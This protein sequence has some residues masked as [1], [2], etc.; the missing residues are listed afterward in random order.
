MLE[1]AGDEVSEKLLK[2]VAYTLELL[3]GKDFRRQHSGVRILYQEP[4][5]NTSE[6]PVLYIVPSGFFG[7]K[8]GTADSLPVLPLQQIDGIPLLFG[9]PKVERKGKRVIVYA[10]IIASAFFLVTRYEE[11][12]RRDVRDEHG[13]F[14][15][16]ESLPYRAGFIDCPIVEDYA[17]LLRK[18][19][20]EAGV[21]VEE[22]KREFTVLLTHDV[23]SIRK[24]RRI[25]QPFRQAAKAFLGREPFGSI[26]ESA[27][28]VLGLKKDPYNNFEELFELAESLDEQEVG[29]KRESVY[30][31]MSG[32][33]GKYASLYNIRAKD[34]KRIIQE[35][36]ESGAGI[37]LHTSYDAGLNPELI[38]K[39]KTLL[40]DVCGFAIRGNRYHYLAWREVEDGWSLAKAGI[41]WDST[42]GYADVA[43]FRL[44]VCRPIELFDPVR[45]EPF[46]I[47][48][49]PL[50]VMECTLSRTN[51]MNLGEEEAFDYCKKLIDQTRKY[52]GEFVMLWHN[53][54]FFPVAGNYHPKL[55]RRLLREFSYAE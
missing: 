44:G 20:R 40:E 1:I 38:E 30:F 31:F 28:V 23:D 19:L 54:M 12:V 39:E 47:E 7:E 46:G 45:M 5:E 10:D 6:Y 13:R 8:Y 22:P 21:N 34:V 26:L 18:W 3:L 53:T 55:Y 36:S 16:K 37:G 29:P 49:H 43:G 17:G 25:S 42:L 11:V 33:E 51:Y 35:V 27:A 14:P 41:N 32:G 15:G 2:C 52:N 50:I 48:E 9:S 24:Y 4:E